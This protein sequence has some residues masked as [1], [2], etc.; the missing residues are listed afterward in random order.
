MEAEEAELSDGSNSTIM[1]Y[2][3]HR[4]F[5]I[6]GK[7]VSAKQLE[8]TQYTAGPTVETKNLIRNFLRKQVMEGVAKM[9]SDQLVACVVCGEEWERNFSRTHFWEAHVA[10]QRF[11]I[12]RV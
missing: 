7:R 1:C 10:Y 6:T 11:T 5:Q 9:P 3:C 8:E 4:R 2:S 12:V